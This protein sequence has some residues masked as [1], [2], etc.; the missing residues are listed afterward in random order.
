MW[1]VRSSGA[2][3]LPP[4]HLW[5]RP[6]PWRP[7]LLVFADQAFGGLDAQAH[8]DDLLE[9]VDLPLFVLDPLEKLGVSL[10]DLVEAH[11]LLHLGSHFQEVDEVA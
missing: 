10:A 8:G 9:K 3:V 7:L 11:A 4:R 6:C 5:R 2:R 1:L